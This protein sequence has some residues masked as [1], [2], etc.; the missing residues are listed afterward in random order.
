MGSNLTLLDL[1]TGRSTWPEILKIL[2]P[3]AMVAASAYASGYW[4][5][6]NAELKKYIPEF[7]RKTDEIL[8]DLKKRTDASRH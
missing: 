1:T 7:R 6:R 8:D 3:F 5:G 4:H 2:W